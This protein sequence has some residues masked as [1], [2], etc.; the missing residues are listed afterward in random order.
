MQ[1]KRSVVKF[2]LKIILLSLNPKT[3]WFIKPQMMTTTLAIQVPPNRGW[4]W[5]FTIFTKTTMHPV[6][7]PKIL[8]IR[9]LRFSLGM[10]VI[11]RRNWKQWL[12][13]ILGGRQRALWSMWKRWIFFTFNSA[14]NFS[15]GVST[16]GLESIT[17]KRQIFSIRIKSRPHGK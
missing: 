15:N 16:G 2:S 3:Y 11:S 1:K 14:T 8:P 17:W 9:C 13:K 6:Y 5:E 12:C 10:N 7:P 4:K